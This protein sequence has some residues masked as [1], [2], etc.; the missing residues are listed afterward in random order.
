MFL[1]SNLTSHAV[2][3]TSSRSRMEGRWRS[4]SKQN[5]LK[6]LVTISLEQNPLG[7]KNH[8][9]TQEITHNFM[10]SKVHYCV[11]NS[12][13]LV[14][15]HGPTNLVP[16]SPKLPV[17]YFN[18]IVASVAVFQVVSSLYIFQPKLFINFPLL[19][20]TAHL[21]PQYV[22]TVQITSIIY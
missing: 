14:P 6:S 5:N 2:L 3:R 13:P 8:C 10:H 15:L 9:T 17:I 11:H 19:L 7:S 16:H 21:F 1:T 4:L 12:L 22:N 20:Q 18:I